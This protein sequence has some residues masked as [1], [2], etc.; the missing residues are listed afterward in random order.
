[1]SADIDNDGIYNRDDN[2]IYVYN[3]NQSDVDGDKIGDKCDNCPQI[4]NGAQSGEKASL[5][6]S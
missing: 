4:F 2:C 6:L 5:I 3:P 1:M